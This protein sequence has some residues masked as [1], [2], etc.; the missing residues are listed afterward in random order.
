MEKF[1]YKVEFSNLGELENQLNKFGS[2]SW[3]LVN[4]IQNPSG[5]FVYIFKRIKK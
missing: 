4:F 2:L 1:E 3:E 5:G